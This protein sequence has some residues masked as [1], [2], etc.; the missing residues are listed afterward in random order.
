MAI[1]WGSMK[2]ASD[3]MQENQR[4]EQACYE[5]A[6]QELESQAHS[7]IDFISKVLLRAQQI[8]LER[9]RNNG[10]K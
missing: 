5:Q 9:G 2:R 4:L 8:K 6:Q 1:T 3:Y 10:K 7:G